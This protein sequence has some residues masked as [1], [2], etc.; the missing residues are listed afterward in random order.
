MLS[1]EFLFA[2]RKFQKPA[3]QQILLEVKNAALRKQE[4]HNEIHCFISV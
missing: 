1:A 3:Y 2:A 4:N